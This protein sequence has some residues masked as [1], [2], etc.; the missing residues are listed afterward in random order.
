MYDTVAKVETLA[1]CQSIAD[2][3]SKHNQNSRLI[4]V[5]AAK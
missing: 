5:T 2:T 3:I 4:C 1:Q